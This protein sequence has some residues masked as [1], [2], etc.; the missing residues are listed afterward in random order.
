MMKLGAGDAEGGTV[1]A[2]GTALGTGAA[3]DDLQLMEQ[4]SSPLSSSRW[5]TWHG[6]L[7]TTFHGLPL[8]FH[9]RRPSC[10]LPQVQVASL[11]ADDAPPRTLHL[12]S[13]V[14]PPP[15]HIQTTGTVPSNHVADEKPPAICSVG[16]LLYAAASAAAASSATAS[17]AAAS[18]AAVTASSAA[19]AAAASAA[20]YPLL[21]ASSK[22][23]AYDRHDAPRFVL[24]ADALLLRGSVWVDCAIGSP[25]TRSSPLPF[26][27]S[28]HS[29]FRRP[30]H[31]LSL[32]SH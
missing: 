10:D 8:T 19:S 18:S 2:L 29:P 15:L 3:A 23:V 32:T 22:V 1:E 26:H 27:S 9:R 25:L 4:V 6:S 21:L 31:D 5:S 14:L 7:L 13:A 17:A 20:E 24:E 30:F 11:A 28:V 12:L 16:G